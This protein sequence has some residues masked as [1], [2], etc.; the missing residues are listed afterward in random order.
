MIDR[1]KS[2][3]GE[4]S[5]VKYLGNKKQMIEIKNRMIDYNSD[6]SRDT[7]TYEQYYVDYMNKL[8]QGTDINTEFN[9]ETRYKSKVIYECEVLHET[10]LKHIEN[11]KICNLMFDSSSSNYKNIQFQALDY[12]FKY[13]KYMDKEGKDC[14]TRFIYFKFKDLVEEIW[15]MDKFNKIIDEDIEY[16]N[17]IK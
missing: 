13:V 6:L 16:L 14:F 9:L 2:G 4:L 17:L 8:T 15:K 3:T 7:S 10:E 12:K 11:K 5:T 1:K